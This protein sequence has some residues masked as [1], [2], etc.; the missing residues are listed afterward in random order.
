MNKLD[1]NHYAKRREAKESLA[2]YLSEST[3]I[4][5]IQFNKGLDIIAEWKFNPFI[6]PSQSGATGCK[7]TNIGTV[8]MAA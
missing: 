7:L 1:F 3:E 4:D 5:L 2:Q 6:Q 8:Q